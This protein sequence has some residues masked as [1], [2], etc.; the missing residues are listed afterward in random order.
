[1]PSNLP[2]SVI[3]AWECLAAT[4]GKDPKDCA[5]ADK[6]EWATQI[7]PF[8]DLDDP[9]SPSLRAFILGINNIIPNVIS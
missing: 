6:S 5:G 3:G 9:K 1:L 7:S 4:L 8:L 2:D